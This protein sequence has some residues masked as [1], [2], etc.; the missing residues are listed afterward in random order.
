MKLNKSL[1][2]WWMAALLLGPW[3]GQAQSYA[4]DWFTIDGGGGVSK[5]GTYTLVGTVGQ[6]DAGRLTSEGR[7]VIGGFWGWISTVETPGAPELTISQETSTGE[8]LLEWPAPST[9]WVLQESNQ[10]QPAGTWSA[11]STVPVL[12]GSHRRV[13]ILNPIGNRYYRLFKP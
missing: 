10:L 2:A 4:I 7:S 1:H 8:V 11:V 5:G 3:T 6:P 12:T 9:G 13:T